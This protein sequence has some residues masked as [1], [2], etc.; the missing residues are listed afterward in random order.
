MDGENADFDVVA[1]AGLTP[2]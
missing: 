1:L 2:V